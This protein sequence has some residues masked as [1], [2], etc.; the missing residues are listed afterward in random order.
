MDDFKSMG[1]YRYSEKNNS[2]TAITFLLVGLGIGAIAALLMAPKSGKQI[3]KAVRRRFEDARD[4][5]EEYRDK[6]GDYWDRGS[7]W[8]ADAKERVRPIVKKMRRD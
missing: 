2:A 5:A 1:D 7:E 8:A 3:R 4:A 6:A